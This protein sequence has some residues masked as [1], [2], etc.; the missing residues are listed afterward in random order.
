MSAINNNI[1]TFW[2][3]THKPEQS[4]VCILAGY[5]PAYVSYLV[6]S[7]VCVCVAQACTCTCV[8]N[9]KKRLSL[10]TPWRHTQGEKVLFYSFLT[11]VL[12][13]G[14]WST[15]CPGQFTLGNKN[16]GTNEQ[17]VGWAQELVW[18]TQRRENSLAHARIWTPHCSDYSLVTIPITLSQLPICC[19][20]LFHV[21]WHSLSMKSQSK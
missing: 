21:C 4:S 14:V 8:K 16:T 10:S 6:M 18:M 2:W 3:K 20:T 7:I 19:V 11:S 5:Q 15:S 13:G 17:E 12:D 1:T 9:K